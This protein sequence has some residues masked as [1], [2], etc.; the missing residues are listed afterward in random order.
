MRGSHSR[1]SM[2]E[3]QE[4]QL[5]EHFE[6]VAI[7]LDGDEAAAEIA[8]R[9]VHKLCVR[10]VDVC[11]TASSR[12]STQQQSCR[13]CWYGSDPEGRGPLGGRFVGLSACF[14]D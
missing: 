10:I 2:S 6:R 1:Y 5:V 4:A 7:L 3:Q 13:Y 14:I 11:Q 12:I 8:V 9:L